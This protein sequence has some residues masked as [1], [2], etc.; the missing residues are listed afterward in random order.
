MSKKIAN[1]ICFCSCKTDKKTL[2]KKI[3]LMQSD[4][5]RLVGCRVYGQLSHK[6]KANGWD[7][8]HGDLSKGS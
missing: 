1:M 7:A 4:L 2:V 6:G 8:L 3:T 5:L